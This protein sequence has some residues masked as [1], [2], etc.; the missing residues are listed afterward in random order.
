MCTIPTQQDLE[1]L[2]GYVD[3]AL[4]IL[5]TKDKYL[6][7][8]KVHERTIVARFVIYLKEM[9]SVDTVFC[10]YDLDPEY[11]R[12]GGSSKEIDGYPNG[13]IPD[14]LLHIR[15]KGLRFSKD[16]TNILALEFKT[17][18]N[19]TQKEYEEAEYKVLK[20]KEE[21]NYHLGA[22]IVLKEHREDTET[23]WKKINIRK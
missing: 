6:I 7:E 15:G 10:S 8:N 2:K 4:D 13:I 17:Y 23:S 19:N 11:N 18:W 12:N 1:R 3:S 21:Y 16:E 9:I 14:V 5:Y 22:V 20:L